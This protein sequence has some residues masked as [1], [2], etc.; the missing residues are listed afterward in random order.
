VLSEKKI[1]NET[2]NHTPLLQVNGRSLT[3]HNTIT[4]T[5]IILGTDKNTKIIMVS[6]TL[7]I[8]GRRKGIG[9]N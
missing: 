1:L 7:L 4:I 3:I 9:R 6:L 8:R 2:K 5:I